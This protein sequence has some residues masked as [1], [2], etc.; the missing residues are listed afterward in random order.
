MPWYL[1]LTW[2]RALV[3]SAVSLQTPTTYPVHTGYQRELF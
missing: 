2:H 3:E 1:A